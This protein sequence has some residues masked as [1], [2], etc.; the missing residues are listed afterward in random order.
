MASVS[1]LSFSCFLTFLFHL[2]PMLPL[3]FVF[4]SLSVCGCV[5]VCWC[6]SLGCPLCQGNMTGRKLPQTLSPPLITSLV[7]AGIYATCFMGRVY[8]ENGA[9]ISCKHPVCDEVKQFNKLRELLNLNG[10][11]VFSHLS[12]CSFISGM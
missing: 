10:D 9:T 5:W 3:S 7:T 8:L 12:A 6:V 1:L 4:L 11:L 2:A